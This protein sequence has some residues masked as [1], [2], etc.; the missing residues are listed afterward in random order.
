MHFYFQVDEYDIRWCLLKVRGRLF[1]EM[2][3]L[4]ADLY[5]LTVSVQPN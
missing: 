5:N 2:F 4:L 3:Q 1:I